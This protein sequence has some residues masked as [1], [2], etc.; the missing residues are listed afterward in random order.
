MEPNGSTGIPVW[1]MGHGSTGI[2]VWVM[3]LPV[4]VTCV[5]VCACVFGV[6][7]CMCAS[8]VCDVCGLCVCGVMC[9]A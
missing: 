3:G 9:V 4:W 5:C 7:V 2:P 8:R 1:V 6:C